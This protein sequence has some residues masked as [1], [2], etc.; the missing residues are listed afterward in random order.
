MTTITLSSNVAISAWQTS[1]ATADRVVDGVTLTG[2]AAAAFQF[3]EALQTVRFEGASGG[4]LDGVQLTDG[5]FEFP[6][7]GGQWVSLSEVAD[8]LHYKYGVDPLIEFSPGLG[9]RG[10][11]VADINAVLQ[12]L[13][14]EFKGEFSLALL[15]SAA[16]QSATQIIFDD[17]KAAANSAATYDA[18]GVAALLDATSTLNLT[19]AT[20]AELR[21]RL[22]DGGDLYV[23]RRG[24][25]FIN[26]V[27]T[28]AK[29]VALVSRLLAQDNIAAEYK[30]LM[31]DYAERNNLIAAARSVIEA[32]A[33]GVVQATASLK[34]QYGWNDVLSEL[35][36]GQRSDATFPYWTTDT[37]ANSVTFDTDPAWVTGTQVRIGAT[38]GGL[39]SGTDYFV[40]S[41]GNGTYSFFSNQADALANTNVV[42]LTASVDRSTNVVAQDAVPVSATG[43]ATPVF[44]PAKVQGDSLKNY[45]LMANAY[46][47]VGDQVGTF[48]NY[49]SFS[50]INPGWPEDTQLE[51]TA[52]GNG[53]TAGTSYYVANWTGHGVQLTTSAGGNANTSDNVI[54]QKP[55]G[56]VLL[57]DGGGTPGSET[58]H[59]YNQFTAEGTN[60]ATGSRVQSSQD[61][62]V[63][64]THKHETETLYKSIVSIKAN[65]DYYLRNDG[66]GKYSVYDSVANANNG[67]E[68]GRL[69]FQMYNGT[70][71]GT[72]TRPPYIT[73]ATATIKGLENG[74]QIFGAGSAEY[75]FAAGLDPLWVD[76]TAVQTN[77][78][79]GGLTAGFTYYTR[80][81]TTGGYALYTSQAAALAGGPSRLVPVSTP[82]PGGLFRVADRGLEL[83]SL[84]SDWNEVEALLNTL[85]SNKVRDGDLDQAKLQTLTAQLQNNTEAMTAMLK[86]F[87][88]MNAALVQALR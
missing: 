55:N 49:L 45:D 57:Y 69:Y 32:D 75:S 11:S 80:K 36:S 67:G 58:I 27:P 77:A 25:F 88:D 23:D 26:G 39:T 46:Y 28:T 31:D 37:S 87:S 64:L 56:Q 13:N 42:D 38:S 79:G 20:E 68:V 40:R 43:A 78:T 12:R 1:T 2:M 9:L 35:T 51:F 14:Q 47:I 83:S 70:Y 33:D 85:I 71:T 29:D 30:V 84:S 61:I 6:P 34:Q 76:G 82:L 60:F 81:T 63:L 24:A 21:E 65:T 4:L 73:D 72:G 62:H 48:D 16:V 22:T 52:S 18:A 3:G 10:Y 8:A 7:G 59:G 41:L 66:D 53:V 44:I 74:L 5:R 15:D 19:R 54:T 86:V 17:Q 50:P